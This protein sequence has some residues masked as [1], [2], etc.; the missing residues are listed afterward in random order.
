[1]TTVDDRGTLWER[2]REMEREMERERQGGREGGRVRKKSDCHF[3]LTA[4]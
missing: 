1:M 2:E 4:V 3:K